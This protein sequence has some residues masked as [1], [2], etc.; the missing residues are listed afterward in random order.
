MKPKIW[1]F[2]VDGTLVDSLSISYRVDSEIIREFG[3][4]V[5]DIED[6]R[7]LLGEG[8]WDDFYRKFGVDM[9][10]ERALEL[11]YS[12]VSQYGQRAISGARDL[13]QTLSENNVGRAIVSSVI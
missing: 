7:K 9:E 1:V 10:T 5:P 13:L 3:G 12:R 2:D 8:G 11:Y 6:Y 4:N